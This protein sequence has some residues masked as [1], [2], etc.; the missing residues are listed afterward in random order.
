[1]HSPL[2]SGV[3]DVETLDKG[4]SIFYCIGRG[5]RICK[6]KCGGRVQDLE[7]NLGVG[8]KSPRF[9]PDLTWLWVVCVSDC[10]PNPN[11]WS[12]FGPHKKRAKFKFW[13][14]PEKRAEFKFVWLSKS[15]VIVQTTLLWLYWHCVTVQMIV[16]L[17]K[18]PLL[19][20]NVETL[21]K[22]RELLPWIALSDCPR[23]VW[24]SKL[25]FC[26]C[27]DIVW[28]S[29]GLCDFQILQVSLIHSYDWLC[30]LFDLLWVTVQE[31]C[32]CPNYTPVTV[33]ALCDCP[34]DCVICPR[35]PY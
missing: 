17:S 14:L 28:L 23:V 1:M 30:L 5:E 20:L 12:H 6:I 35:S 25:H 10:K 15:C 19:T 8:V 2:I 29:K 4:C 21:D 27:I 16:W 7:K 33:L 11:V 9:Y 26:D 34:N 24:L 3:L 13:A 22:H 18:V 32:D 31:L